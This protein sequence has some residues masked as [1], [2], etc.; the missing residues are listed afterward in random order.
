MGSFL[1]YKLLFY[2]SQNPETR[3]FWLE[4]GEKELFNNPKELENMLTVF[5]TLKDSNFQQSVLFTLFISNANVQHFPLRKFLILFKDSKSNLRLLFRK[6][7]QRLNGVLSKVFQ[8]MQI[9][10]DEVELPLIL[11]FMKKLESAEIRIMDLNS[12][13]KL[14]YSILK[15]RGLAFQDETEIVYAYFL[16]QKGILTT[17]DA[18]LIYS[19]KASK[20]FNRKS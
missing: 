2:T 20:Y 15:Q 4:W 16:L 11:S 13:A 5:F 12:I 17:S 10:K 14:S 19:K 3:A 1:F 18:E 8:V 6:S 7:P 9:K